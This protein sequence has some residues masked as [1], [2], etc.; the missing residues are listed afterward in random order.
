MSLVQP[1]CRTNKHMETTKNWAVRPKAMQDPR[2]ED[3]IANVSSGSGTWR[4]TPTP[5]LA[6]QHG[7]CSTPPRRH[8]PPSQEPLS[9]AALIR[10]TNLPA[11]FT[12]SVATNLPAL[13][14]TLVAVGHWQCESVME[15]AFKDMLL[16]ICLLHSVCEQNER[17]VWLYH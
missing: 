2:P 11:L 9:A 15:K 8:W 6:N 17:C 1:T 4:G 16:E 10:A 5:G 7:Q 13:F 3:G 12:S 14:T